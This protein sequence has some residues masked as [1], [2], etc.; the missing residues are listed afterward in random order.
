MN[1]FNYKINFA[2]YQF[3]LLLFLCFTFSCSDLPE[4]PIASDSD[5]ALVDPDSVQNATG[6]TMRKAAGSGANSTDFISPVTPI[7]LPAGLV[8]REKYEMLFVDNFNTSISLDR[9]ENPKWYGSVWWKL[10]TED[11]Y[12]PFSDFT[13]HN[14]ASNVK[15]D[16]GLLD[17]SYT[18]DGN[19]Y[20]GGGIV[21]LKT[22]GYGYYE[23]RVKVYTNQKGFH[24][25]F[26]S[27][28]PQVEVDGFELDSG[29]GRNIFTSCKH[30]WRNPYAKYKVSATEKRNFPSV[31][32]LSW[33]E[34]I[35]G[36]WRTLGYEWLPD[37]I[38]FYID[39]VKTNTFFNKD[40]YGN[41]LD[42][43]APS[44]VC[45]TGMPWKVFKSD[46]LPS[47]IYPNASMQVDRFTYS[48]KKLPGVNLL[49]N[50]DFELHYP[51]SNAFRAN[52]CPS[53][54]DSMRFDSDIVPNFGLPSNA[55]LIN[56]TKLVIGTGFVGNW[57][58]KLQKNAFI[59]QTLFYIPD[60][61]YTL[62]AK[63]RCGNPDE[64]SGDEAVMLVRNGDGDV[65]ASKSISTT[66]GNDWV[67]ITLKDVEV[68]DNTAQIIFKTR[69]GF[70]ASTRNY[71]LVD[72]V[73][74]SAQ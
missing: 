70:N 29:K 73:S 55:N 44:N 6:L 42:V 59:Q 14:S 7:I 2:I 48:A 24:Q 37:R 54:G 30:R 46:V 36:A 15:I 26:W 72:D 57:F 31:D 71:L 10:R 9:G 5:T 33:E 27:I 35:Y 25:S 13:A 53:W 69:F 62:T 51:A 47:E 28:S 38:N 8:D 67:T 61:K 68:V 11:F 50:G 40:S 52:Y 45:I 1:Y 65:I 22:F 49:G 43:Y 20:H 56:N 60:G 58:Y 17:I 64:N 63:V 3:L 66:S 18:K 4:L 32:N 34:K 16:K 23:V 19:D 41:D 12:I 74:F 21:S 39:G